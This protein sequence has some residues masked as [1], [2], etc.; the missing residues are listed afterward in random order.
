MK[1]IIIITDLRG[2]D[3][4]SLLSHLEE[5]GWQVQCV[6]ES[7][8]L[9]DEEALSKWAAP[10]SENLEAVVHPAPP[11]ICGSVMDIA[12]A[13]WGLARDEGPMAAWCV[14]KVF[15][16]IM[17]EKRR[18][19]LI[20]L[21]SIHA[22]KPVGMG[23]L[24]SMGCGAVQMLCREFNQDYGT[25]NVRSFFVQR[26]ISSDDPDLRSDVS[27]VYFGLDM[28]YPQRQVPSSGS[29]NG[30]ISFLLTDEAWPLSGSDLRAD[31][32]MT[33]FYN[34]RSQMEGRDYFERLL[35][36]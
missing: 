30:L 4:Q 24:F 23:Y 20:F 22:E 10:F 3:A 19:S 13:D 2:P 33:M 32:G 25:A 27:N 5:T 12:K 28:R 11:A 36:E 9:W 8:C 1:N 16:G 31:G 34:H 15:G 21:N 14:A 18:G 6:P 29:L 7:V 26:G 17:R 35:K